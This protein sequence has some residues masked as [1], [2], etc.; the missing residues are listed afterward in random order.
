MIGPH[1]GA[2]QVLVQP[3]P[4]SPFCAD[5]SLGCL[6]TPFDAIS[7]LNSAAGGGTTTAYGCDLFNH[8][9]DGFAAALAAA[10][11]ADYVVLGLGIETCGLTPAHNVNPAKPGKCFQEKHTDLYVFPDQY[12]E[13]EVGC[14]WCLI[15]DYYYFGP[16]TFTFPVCRSA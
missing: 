13:L 11:D 6:T 2:Q 3:Y 12:L 15:L 4:F 10:K 16:I 8:S 7:T 14:T 5:G 1:A 9:T